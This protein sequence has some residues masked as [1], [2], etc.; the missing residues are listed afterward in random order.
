LFVTF[1]SPKPWDGGGGGSD[2]RGE[3][4]WL[5]PLPLTPLPLWWLWLWL[6]LRRRKVLELLVLLWGVWW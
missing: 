3:S 1:G 2:D 6:L 5:F 4:G